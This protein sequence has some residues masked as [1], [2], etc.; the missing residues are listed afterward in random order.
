MDNLVVNL[1]GQHVPL[2][3][4][5]NT[6]Y[7]QNIDP[8]LV[9]DLKVINNSLFNI[10]TC[11]IGSRPFLR[12]YGSDLVRALF[13]PADEELVRFLDLSLFQSV[14]RWEPRIVADRTR[15]SIVKTPEGNG[16]DID[17]YY[18]IRKTLQ[19]GRYNL[20]LTKD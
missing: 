4:D 15:T 6:N 19:P 3:V 13:E 14:A 10:F 7:G 18:N 1:N 11:P 16:F 9:I 5:V 12:E 8:E 20:T 2:W 17:F